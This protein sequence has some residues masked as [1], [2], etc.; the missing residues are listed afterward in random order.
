MAFACDC[1]DCSGIQKRADVICADSGEKKRLGKMSLPLSE[2]FRPVSFSEV[3]GVK[4][5]EKLQNF[6]SNPSEMPNVLMWGPP[7]TG[8]TSCAK[9]MLKELAP[10]DYIRINGSDTTGVDTIREKV[11]SYMTSMSTNSGKPKIIWIEE[12]DFMSTAAFS[13]LRSMIEQY[14]KN[15]RFIVTLNYINKIPE[16]IQSRFTCI[17]FKRA[18]DEEIYARARYICDTE[19]I[20]VNDDLLFLMVKNCHG[21]IRTAIN[22]I[23][24]SSANEKK[25]ISIDKVAGFLTGSIAAQA[26][27]MI[28]AGEWTKIR[29]EI[30]KLNPDY[31]RV[32]VEL[33]TMF[34]ESD[35]PIVKKAEINN[36]IA[37]GMME[38]SLGFNQ[39][40]SF[41]AICYRIIKV[42]S[43]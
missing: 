5:I 12:F 13:A 25:E 4:D 39:D 14:I 27:E 34:F 43:E 29:Y 26:K 38:L 23:Q 1:G 28:E 19:K 31:N 6:V 37:T 21:D 15:A 2:R 8:K 36:I 30:P 24:T 33:E 11:Y 20:S 10:I 18:S 17:E 40:I 16:P 22:I 32:L 3:V 35:I 41:S 9:I 42:L 7:G